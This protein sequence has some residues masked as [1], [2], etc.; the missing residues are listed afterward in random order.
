MA[1]GG[2]DSQPTV[3][4]LSLN[5]WGLLFSRYRKERLEAIALRLLHLRETC[6]IIALQE[7][8]VE[9]DYQILR[10]A[11]LDSLPY[12]KKWHSGIVTGPG[13]VV[14]SRWPIT[15]SSI[16]RFPLNGRP[17]AVWRGDWYAGKAAGSCVIIHPSGTNIEVFNAH[18]HAPYAP[19]GDNAY[20]CHRTAQA[21]DISWLVRRACESKHAVF[22]VGDFNTR[23]R[24]VNYRLFEQ[25]ARLSDAWVTVKGVFPGKMEDLS[26]ADQIALAGVTS[27]SRL[28]TWRKNYALS[29]AQRLDYILYDQLSAAATDCQVCFVEPI[30]G[31]GSVSDHF[32]VRATFVIRQPSSTSQTVDDSPRMSELLDETIAVIKH[33]WPTA[34]RQSNLR[35][36]HFYIS[37]AIVLG[38]LIAVWW[39]AAD[40]RAYVAFIFLLLG[41]IIA[42][43]GTIDGLLGYVFGSNEKRALLEFEDQV[44]IVRDVC[45]K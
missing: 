37:M 35:L 15:S 31:I 39:G 45:T 10:S 13:L 22:C 33:Y 29:R 5:C 21:W 12:S 25:V 4:F 30:P 18:L 28:N 40:G 1:T 16:Y 36:L 20:E 11:V 14:F 6:D 2:A 17:S 19:T 23:P 9:A 34:K 44:R 38:M 3:R 32:G 7:V 24:T 26:P 43:T 8:W 41:V 42:I 27:D